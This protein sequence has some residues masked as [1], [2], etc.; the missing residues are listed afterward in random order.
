MFV[1]SLVV[2]V[3]TLHWDAL[4]AANFRHGLLQ[5]VRNPNIGEAH[6]RHYA[7][8]KSGIFDRSSP[9][10]SMC[11]EHST[12]CHTPLYGFECLIE[13]ED[14]LKFESIVLARLLWWIIVKEILLRRL[15]ISNVS[16]AEL[17]DAFYFIWVFAS[18]F[19]EACGL[20]LALA[21][22]ALRRLVTSLL[23][24]WL[25]CDL[26]VTLCCSLFLWLTFVFT[27]LFV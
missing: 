11:S 21:N 7:E 14:G 2:F 19:I 3:S 20:S 5:P 25:L 23:G 13:A 8:P 18:A 1:G 15:V 16:S 4:S 10:I 17:V 22:H 27:H 12:N 6:K 24:C 9:V 26:S